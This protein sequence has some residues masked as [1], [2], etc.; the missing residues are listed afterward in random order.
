[1]YTLKFK[2]L[3]DATSHDG[4]VSWAVN[5]SS[6][7]RDLQD[8]PLFFLIE[9][10][11][12][13]D[14]YEVRGLRELAST[15]LADLLH[16]RAQLE[17]D[18]QVAPAV[19]LKLLEM[20]YS[21][22]PEGAS[23]RHVL[24]EHVLSSDMTALLKHEKCKEVMMAHP[25]FLFDMLK[26]QAKDAEPVRSVCCDKKLAKAIVVQGCD[27]SDDPRALWATGAHFNEATV[28]RSFHPGIPEY[29]S[30]KNHLLR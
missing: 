18:D 29:K 10:Y 4:K 17:E 6:L 19:T 1:M 26:V 8:L 25:V 5:E 24:Q 30:G 20:A 11:V 23:V 13:A 16:S 7:P 21:L 22:T 3:A 28:V 15:K 9:V 2:T 27:E 12:A 14:K